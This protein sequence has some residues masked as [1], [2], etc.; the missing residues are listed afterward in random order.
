MLHRH[1][2]CVIACI[3]VWTTQEGTVIA[4]YSTFLSNAYSPNSTYLLLARLHIM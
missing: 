3:A 1:R 4:T 2:L